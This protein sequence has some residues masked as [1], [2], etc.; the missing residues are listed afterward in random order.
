MADLVQV[1]GVFRVEMFMDAATLHAAMGN[2]PAWVDTAWTPK[3]LEPDFFHSRGVPFK[4][5]SP[6]H[7][8]ARKYHQMA[9][10]VEHAGPAE[11]LVQVAMSLEHA[12]M[13]FLKQ[14][15]LAAPKYEGVYFTKVVNSTNYPGIDGK[16][17]YL[18]IQELSA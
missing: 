9:V 15:L 2:Q 18:C 12:N 4:Y 17:G 3:G 7:S 1:N 13:H 16:G 10:D 5:P 8:I 6:D 14:E 11:Y